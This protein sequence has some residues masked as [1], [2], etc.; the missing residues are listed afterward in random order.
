MKIAEKMG[1]LAM[2]V[3]AG[4]IVACS[5]ENGA[6]GRNAEEVNVDSLAT[7]IRAEITGTLWDSL[8]AK[9]YVDTVSPLARL[10]WIPQGRHWWTA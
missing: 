8:Y 7:A 6:D 10:G 5:G 4:L 1:K 3:M 2:A 9:P